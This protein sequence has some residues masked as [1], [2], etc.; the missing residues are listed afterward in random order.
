MR[1]STHWFA[2]IA[3]ASVAVTA[4]YVSLY[5]TSTCLPPTRQHPGMMSQSVGAFGAAAAVGSAG[6]IVLGLGAGSLQDLKLLPSFV[7]SQPFRSH[8]LFLSN[9]QHPETMTTSVASSTASVSSST[10][11]PL[12]DFHLAPV[13]KSHLHPTFL[14]FLPLVIDAQVFAALQ[15]KGAREDGERE[16]EN[17]ITV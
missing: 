17:S 14:H 11:M 7:Q 16:E 3:S 8:F 9:F 12:H 10:T 2:H 6:A 1:S 4:E 13:L 15:R 5:S